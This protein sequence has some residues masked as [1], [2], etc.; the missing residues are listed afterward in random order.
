MTNKIQS[1][2]ASKC[3]VFVSVWLYVRIGAILLVGVVGSIVPIRLFAAIQINWYMLLIIFFVCVFILP[4]L[5]SLHIADP[6][7]EKAW[8]R[9]SWLVNPFSISEPIQFI[10]FAAYL[11]IMQGF[12]ILVRI[13]LNSLPFHLGV[14]FPITFG[15]GLL[16]GIKITLIIFRSRFTPTAKG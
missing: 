7:S 10:H 6:R 9:P 12:I 4:V 8:L 1:Q 3:M 2:S 5:V 14:L 15:L 13:A 11:S 16:L